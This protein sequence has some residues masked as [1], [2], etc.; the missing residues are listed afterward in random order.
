MQFHCGGWIK[1]DLDRLILILGYIYDVWFNFG[2]YPVTTEKTYTILTIDI[3]EQF[4]HKID[5]F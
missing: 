4:I 2:T 1:P 5:D 3:H